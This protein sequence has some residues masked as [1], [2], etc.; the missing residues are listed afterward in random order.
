[1]PTTSGHDVFSS[2]AAVAASILLLDD[3]TVDL[4]VLL[5]GCLIPNVIFVIT[6]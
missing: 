2:S 6:I 1:M 5:A 4:Q 3:M